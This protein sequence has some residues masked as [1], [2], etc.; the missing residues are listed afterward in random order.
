MERGIT[1]GDNVRRNNPGDYTHGR[2]GLALELTETRARVLWT[3]EGS[4]HLMRDPK[5][6]WVSINQ[7]IR[8]P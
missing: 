6:T 4:G 7:L 8:I 5:K 1:I 2:R 3:H